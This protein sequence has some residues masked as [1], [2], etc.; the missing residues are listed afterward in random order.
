MTKKSKRP[1]HGVFGAFTLLWVLSIGWL[2]SPLAASASEAKTAK[3][4]NMVL[5]VGDDLGFE[6]VTANGGESYRTP[7][8]DALAATGV[9]FTQA[10]A[11][12][13]CLLIGGNRCEVRGRSFMFDAYNS[14]CRGGCWF[15][16]CGVL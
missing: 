7:N 4:P 6:A 8:I 15:D 13:L 12:P 9:R 16:V 2:G 14:L 3:R 1:R 11:S 5:I 10:F